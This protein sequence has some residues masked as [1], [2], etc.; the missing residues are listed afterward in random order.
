LFPL[1]RDPLRNRLVGFA[2]D[3]WKA[4]VA[5]GVEETDAEA[6]CVRCVPTV[7][8]RRS[9]SV[10][11]AGGPVDVGGGGAPK[12]PAEGPSGWRMIV[13]TG[14]VGTGIVVIVRA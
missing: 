5:A 9:E 6:W 3:P 7:F 4:D 1:E 13:E 11:A 8:D 14:G 2:L 12:P 10:S